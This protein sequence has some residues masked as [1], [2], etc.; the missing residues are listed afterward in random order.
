MGFR[1]G[2]GALEGW[3]G[4]GTVCVSGC[5]VDHTSVSASLLSMLQT[6]VT[7]SLDSCPVMGVKA[8]RLMT[9]P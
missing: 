4:G 3:M 8:A 2:D 1:R 6:Y 7:T 5:G 9:L